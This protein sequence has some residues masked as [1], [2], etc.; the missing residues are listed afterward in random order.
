MNIF[1]AMAV[2]DLEEASRAIPVIDVAPA[3]R[4]APGGLEAVAAQVRSASEQV[5][6]FY[7]AGHGVPETL[8]DSA[9]AGTREIVGEPLADKLA[10]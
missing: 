10:L 3:F 8:I 5:G 1:K 4:G 6:F 7:V 9:L 2:K